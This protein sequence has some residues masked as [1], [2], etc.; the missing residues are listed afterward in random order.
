MGNGEGVA[1]LVV[2]WYRATKIVVM[3]SHRWRCQKREARRGTH[4]TIVIIPS[5]VT[6]EEQF[7]FGFGSSA[8]LLEMAVY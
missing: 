4:L 8:K 5:L 1:R 7:H 3:E 6:S 2:L